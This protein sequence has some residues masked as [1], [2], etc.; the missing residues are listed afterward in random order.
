M[1]KKA[2]VTKPSFAKVALTPQALLAKL[3]AQGLIVNDDSAALKYI[4]YVGHFRLKGYW[5]QLQ[6]SAIKNFSAKYNV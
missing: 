5:Y 2:L 3:K 1:A 6:D 4:A